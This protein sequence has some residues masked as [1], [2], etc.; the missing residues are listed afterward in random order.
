MSIREDRYSVHV[1]G[2]SRVEYRDPARTVVIGAGMRD[3][4]VY[5]G[6]VEVVDGRLDPADVAEVVERVYHHLNVTRGMGLSFVNPDGSAWRPQGRPVP[7]AV[8]SI[9]PSIWQ[10]LRQA[11]TGGG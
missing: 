3:G 6:E 8:A 2:L 10:R 4:E 5:P 11:F 1:S 9:G 7:E